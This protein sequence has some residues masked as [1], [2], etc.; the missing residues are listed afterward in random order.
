MGGAWLPLISL[1]HL[2]N[3]SE[4]NSPLPTIMPITAGFVFEHIAKQLPAS[5]LQRPIYL[6]VCVCYGSGLPRFRCWGKMCVQEITWS[7]A[8]SRPSMPYYTRKWRSCHICHCNP[9]TD[10]ASR[11]GAVCRHNYQ[12]ETQLK[13]VPSRHGCSLNL[14]DVVGKNCT[15]LSHDV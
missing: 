12:T 11:Q 14:L 15:G 6:L 9:L 8:L 13:L 2:H 7:S 5:W 10:V 4:M 3:L 1:L